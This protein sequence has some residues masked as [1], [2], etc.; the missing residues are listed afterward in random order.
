MHQP[1]KP[2]IQSI[3]V[4]LSPLRVPDDFDR[5][6]YTTEGRL[7]RLAHEPNLLS[8]FLHIANNELG[9]TNITFPT[10]TVLA[11]AQG[12][13]VQVIGVFNAQDL[14]QYYEPTSPTSYNCA[15]SLD[16]SVINISWPMPWHDTPSTII[17]YTPYNL[18]GL[19]QDRLIIHSITPVQM[20][21]RGTQRQLTN[22]KIHN[23]TP[24]ARD[25]S[26]ITQLN[27]DLQQRIVDAFL[28]YDTRLALKQIGKPRHVHRCERYVAEHDAILQ[29]FTSAAEH[30]R[31]IDDNAAA[32]EGEGYLPGWLSSSDSLPSANLHGSPR[33]PP[34]DASESSTAHY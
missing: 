29:G 23:E 8:A 26:G 17:P 1:T 33:S 30:Q 31:F 20:P 9:I 28:R 22:L 13:S 7:M 34:N 19:V 18:Q 2:T 16:E 21:E 5:E 4:S 32:L 15:H 11:R 3:M 10:A 24:C 6:D 14:P 12:L 25:K 27:D